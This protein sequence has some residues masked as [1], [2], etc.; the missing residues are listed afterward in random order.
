MREVQIARTLRCI[1]LLPI[2]TLGLCVILSTLTNV[3]GCR[4]LAPDL[5]F[6]SLMVVFGDLV[7]V[8]LPINRS[9]SPLGFGT[10][11]IS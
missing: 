2:V 8:C 1:H 6:I 3:L 4:C 9:D 11:P 10:L 7:C 5:L